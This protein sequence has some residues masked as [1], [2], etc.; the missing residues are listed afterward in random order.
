MKLRL[1]HNSI[2]LRLL[3]GELSVFNESGRIAEKIVFPDGN[4]LE[5]SLVRSDD[6]TEVD[7]RIDGSGLI[8]TIPSSVADEWTGTDA[9]GI[10]SSLRCDDGREL[11]I[12]VEKDFVC[13][14]RKDDPDN[15]DAFPNPAVKC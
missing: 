10:E 14:D 2:R 12:L 13:I 8:L 6:A 3:R 15:V 4:A 11:R 9:V 7:A 5:Y 1:R